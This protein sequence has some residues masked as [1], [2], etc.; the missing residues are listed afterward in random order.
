MSIS[1]SYSNINK[2]NALPSYILS[3]VS[4]IIVAITSVPSN[5]VDG[6][7]IL[8]T[9]KINLPDGSNIVVN[10]P[11]TPGVN[12][13]FGVIQD[14][15]LY[16]NVGIHYMYYE[17]SVKYENGWIES[18]GG[19]PDVYKYTALKI[20]DFNVSRNSLVSTTADFM[21]N[22][23]ADPIL[24]SGNNLNVLKYQ[25]Q[26]YNGSAYVNIDSVPVTVPSFTLNEVLE[27]S[28]P[29]AED[30]SYKTK[31]IIYDLFNYV[32]IID[33]LSTTSVPISWGPSGVG[34]GKIYEEYG[35]VIPKLDLARPFVHDGIVQPVIFMKKPSDPDPDGMEDGDLLFIYNDLQAFTSNNFPLEFG[36]SFI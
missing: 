10:K 2:N 19:Y 13:N 32:E 28:L 35:D 31:I 3:N 24:I 29:Y 15:W 5:P 4:Q 6:N 26:Y 7:P 14:N 18:G 9:F 1:H 33:T 21:L 23:E 16:P 22:F 27:H 11:Y 8:A 12:H 36:E 17:V 20:T 30:A 34:I 25:K